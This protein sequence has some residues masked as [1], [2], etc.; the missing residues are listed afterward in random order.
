MLR[1]FVTL[2]RPENT[3]MPAIAGVSWSVGWRRRLALGAEQV[4]LPAARIKAVLVA[5]VASLRAGLR[6]RASPPV[7]GPA[8]QDV[9]R[10]ER[11][12][13]LQPSTIRECLDQVNVLD[14]RHLLRLL[15]DDFEHDHRW[16]WHFSLALDCPKPRPV[17]APEHGEAMEVEEASGL[18]RHDE[19]RAAA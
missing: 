17:Q 2:V 8:V 10:L 19:R 16:R 1:L 9:V 18:Y 15:A 13:L 4:R 14:E 12:S 7:R 5:L 11:C 3:E 6:S